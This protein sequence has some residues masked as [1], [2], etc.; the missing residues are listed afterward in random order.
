MAR[1]LIIEDDS[2]I[3]HVY[4]LILKGENHDVQQ[5]EN[6]KV[7]L[8]LQSKNPFDLIITDL[9]MP[10]KEGLET[11]M[12]IRKDY[13]ETKIIAMSAGVKYSVSDML[14]FAEKFGADRVLEK[15]IPNQVL[16]DSVRELLGEIED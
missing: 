7:G 12:E 13:P 3:R 5:A 16:K 6:G 1:I 4:S 2:N 15:P 9:H 10:E 8:Q 11:I 14:K